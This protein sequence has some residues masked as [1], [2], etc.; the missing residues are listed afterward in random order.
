MVAA[1]YVRR[2]ARVSVGDDDADARET[3]LDD[4][5]AARFKPRALL[6]PYDSLKSLVEDAMDQADAAV[7]DHHLQTGAFAPC[8]GAAVLNELYAKQF[9]ALLVT[10]WV[11][12]DMDEIRRYRRRIPVLLTPDQA[13]GDSI[14]RGLDVCAKE[15]RSEY[16]PS[17][18]PW[19][20]LVRIED[21]DDSQKD[22]IVYAV[23]PGWNS[24]E[25]VRFPR[26]IIPQR[27]H[28]HVTP[29]E[30]FFALVNKGAEDQSELY[31]DEF[32]YRG[33]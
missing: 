17:R 7:F 13:D 18:R 5:K 20:S 27:L 31:F 30:R 29:G 16:L 24:R 26:S 2:F 15:F 22:T 19:K 33:T 10:A 21:V 32:E 8:S 4:L 28:R 25:V 14:A 9:P 23:V 1:R 12:A 6:G 11:R 3:L